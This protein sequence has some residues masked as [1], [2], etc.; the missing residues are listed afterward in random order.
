MRA[1]SHY[2]LSTGGR[3]ACLPLRL[4][5]KPTS[6]ASSRGSRTCG[7][8]RLLPKNSTST[9]RTSLPSATSIRRRSSQRPNAGHPSADYEDRAWGVTCHLLAVA[10]Q[11]S[12]LQPAKT[13]RAHDDDI[14]PARIGHLEDG[15]GD[16]TL[17]H[18]Q[19]D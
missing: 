5:W 4:P 12:I 15:F 6:G 8:G 11:N 19:V 2:M 10:S 13:A 16:G 17:D 1:S 18:L 9:I 3:L 7:S 14:T